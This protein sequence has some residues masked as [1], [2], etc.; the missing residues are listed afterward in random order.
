MSGIISVLVIVGIIIFI[1]SIRESN[2]YER[3]RIKKEID[4]KNRI[5]NEKLKATNPSNILKFKKQTVQLGIAN[6]KVFFAD[7]GEITTILEGDWSQST[8]HGGYDNFYKRYEHPYVGYLNITTAKRKAEWFIKELKGD[9]YRT[10]V[11]YEK[12]PTHSYCGK[13]VKAEIIEENEYPEE[14]DVAYLE[15]TNEK[16]Q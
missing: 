16:I 13:P 10:V 12:N 3:E 15:Y 5:E 1:D 7:G 8:S 6:V 4:E 14:I 11:D 9:E 2:I